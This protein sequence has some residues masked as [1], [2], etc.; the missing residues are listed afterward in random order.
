MYTGQQIQQL[1]QELNRWS[2]LTFTRCNDPG[3]YHFAL[4]HKPSDIEI[5]FSINDNT[6]RYDI[7]IWPEIVLREARTRLQLSYFDRSL[8]YLCIT[9]K[10]T[11]PPDAMAKHIFNNL[12]SKGRLIERWNTAKSAAIA[13]RVADVALTEKKAEFAEVLDGKL[14][15]RIS[16]T[17]IGKAPS[18]QGKV[19][20]VVV[21]AQMAGDGDM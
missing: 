2:G 8:A 21:Q 5:K 7:R 14:V 3:Y 10:A 4:Q 19:S 12:L 9:S 15:D 11:R 1:R 16:F 17:N 6:G 20:G 13:E 18:I